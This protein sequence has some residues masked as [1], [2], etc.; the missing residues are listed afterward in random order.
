MTKILHY[1]ISAIFLGVIISVV[2]IST[3]DAQN[4]IGT[5]LTR[6]DNQNRAIQSL[7]ADLTMDKY[8]AGLQQHD[9]LKLGSTKYLPKSKLTGNKLYARVDWRKPVE[10][11]L[12]VIGDDYILYEPRL[13]RVI[14]GN[15]QKAKGGSK[16]GSVLGFMTM[17]KQQLNDNYTVIYLGDEQISDGTTTFHLQLNPKTPQSYKQAELWVDANGLPRQSKVTEQNNDTT[18]LLLTNIQTNIKIDT[19]IFVLDYPSSI[20]PIRN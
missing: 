10:E 2:S 14:K 19:K 12:S 18:T 8:D 1:S 6:M 15:T 17:S 3:A 13:Q 20:K 4:T 9:P 5:I 11:Q 16:V 7:Q